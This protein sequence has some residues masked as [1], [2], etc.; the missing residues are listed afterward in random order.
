ML[1]AFDRDE[2]GDRAAEKL[3][4][5]LIEAGISL[6]PGAIPAGHGRERIRVQDVA[7]GEVAGAGAEKRG[8]HG[9][10]REDSSEDAAPAIET[11]TVSPRSQEAGGGPSFFSCQ[12]W[13]PRPPRRP[14]RSH[15]QA[16]VTIWK[17]RR[18]MRSR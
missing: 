17:R 15:Q 1:I 13:R 12:R 7:A 5:Q 18:P 11:A 8:V 16:P 6:L 2:A 14:R 9:Q 10:G 3:A 4:Q